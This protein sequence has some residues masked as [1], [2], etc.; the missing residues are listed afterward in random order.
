[1]KTILTTT[2]I[3]LLSNTKR[4]YST[5][6][7]T[8]DQMRQYLRTEPERA[9]AET[10]SLLK[11]TE[12][13]DEIVLLHTD[14][15]EARCCAM[16]IQQFLKGKE[17]ND[18]RLV[19]LQIA[20][21]ERHLESRG[22]RN[23]VNS[24]ITEIERAQKQE[25][26]I[27][28][29]A[30]AGFKAEVVY[31]TM[32]GMLYQVPVKYLYEKFQSLVTFNPVPLGWDTSLILSYPSFFHWIDSDIRHKCDIESRLAGLPDKDYIRALLTLP[33]ED[34]HIFLSP[35]GEV[36]YRRFRREQQE[37]QAIED[38]PS[39]NIDKID[40]KIASSLLKQQHHPPKGILDFC[41]QVANLQPVQQIIGGNYE[42]TT[43]T[44]IKRISDD[45][46]IYVLWADQE[47]AQN[48]I[49]RTTAQGHAQTRKVADWIQQLLK[50]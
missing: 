17:Y 44:R 31:S 13:R 26:E 33:D 4:T 46:L 6:T 41:H 49:V 16:L 23:L 30:T 5:E 48:L 29:N 2:G 43:L 38:P 47:K 37:A 12:P 25:R 7:P 10:N 42:N 20:D 32:L 8:E 34:G 35:I 27:I 11:F 24:L 19:E 9:S 45:G 21:D 40:D 50:N 18:V 15:D 22:L 3:S 28:I 14:T 36:I 39:A 1:M